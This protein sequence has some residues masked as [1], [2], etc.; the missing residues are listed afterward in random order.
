MT[1]LRKY[2]GLLFGFVAGSCSLVA[3]SPLFKAIHQPGYLA[4]GHALANSFTFVAIFMLVCA[5]LN[6]WAC[7]AVL[8]NKSS[9]RIAGLIASMLPL[10][11]L[12][13]V[14]V[15]AQIYHQ[16]A[17]IGHVLW[18]ALPLAVAGCIAFV[19]RYSAPQAPNKATANV[20]LP[21]DGT[22][23]WMNKAVWIIAIVLFFC[24]EWEWFQWANWNSLFLTSEFEFLFDLVLAELVTTLFH[25]LGHTLVGLA[26]GMK[27]RAFIVGPFQWH[28]RDGIW[29]FNFKPKGFFSAG[30][31]TALVP[32]DPREPEWHRILMVAGGPAASLFTGM[33]A[34]LIAMSSVGFPW[35]HAWPFFTCVATLSLL[36]AM[37][38]LIPVRTGNSYSDGAYLYQIMS[39]GIWADYHRA[40]SAVTASLVTPLRPRD[41]DIGAI[42]RVS[43][44]IT[45]GPRAMLLRLHASSYY[46]DRGQIALALHAFSKA[47]EICRESV[48]DLPLEL[49]APFVFRKA[50]LQRDASG[51]RQ[52]WDRMEAKKPTR[53]RTDYWLAS[54]ALHW[55]EGNISEAR[56]AWNKANAFAQQLPSAGAYEFDRYRCEL[57]KEAIYEAPACDPFAVS[58]ETLSRWNR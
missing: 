45:S 31:A 34:A 56:G 47:E 14:I 50:Y 17:G 16:S 35:E 46:L 3:V 9:A 41:Y 1:E 51:A 52:W 44:A 8:K 20:S 27:L 19:P 36:A 6:A 15:A 22:H 32:T 37:L 11:G 23:P 26:V 29:E 18:L 12:V 43:L 13:P 24:F 33:A 21:G 55:I 49:H 10:L 38:N 58:N 2:L 25:E 53:L 5:I 48:S 57:L 40:V 28:I 54:A 39:G 7:W 4:A 30:G 42:D